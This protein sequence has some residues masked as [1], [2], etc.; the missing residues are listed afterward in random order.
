VAQRKRRKFTPEFKAEVV[1]LCLRGDRTIG[2]VSRDLDLT[3]TAVRA[4]V[5]Q[6]EVDLGKGP[7]EALTTSEREELR[8]L[9]REVR[10]LREDREILKKAARLLREGKQVKF[11]FIHAEKAHHSI[12]ALCRVLGVAP[13]G[14]HAWRGR[15]PST[16]IRAIHARSRG[17]Y[18]SPRVHA[19]LRREGFR[20]S[21][22]RVVRLM[23]A[24][25]LE[26]QRPKR[27]RATTDSAH[28]L[29]VA[30]NRLQ[31]DFTAS[32]PDEF[33]V[34]DITYIRTWEGWLYLAAIVD[35]F[36]RRVVGWAAAEH[37]RTE[38]VVEALEKAVRHRQPAEELTFHSDR[39][40]QYAAQEYRHRLEAHGVVPSMSRRGNCYDNAVVESFFG[41]LKS[42]LVAPRPWP[43]RRHVID[44]LEDYIDVFYNTE[45]LHSTLDY[46]TPAEVEQEHAKMTR[47]A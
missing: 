16:Y 40:S 5:K 24:A 1:G 7:A 41:S 20:V 10:Q 42:E 32:A 37:M 27:W 17:T 25:G 2:Q 28:D 6:A 35:L 11:A 3:E 19:Q 36:S 47:A 45:R 39:G 8:R 46:R 26:G 31:Q 18:G 30:P 4:W 34:G 43:S 13:S 14:Y 12:V 29:A 9:R 23:L 44:A 38:L 21:R 15:K 33:W 22:K